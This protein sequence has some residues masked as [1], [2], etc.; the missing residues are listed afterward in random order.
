MATLFSVIYT[1]AL[2]KF[3]EQSFAVLESADNEDFLAQCLVSA[4]SDF[5]SQCRYDLSQLNV[6][7][8]AYVETLGNSEIDVLA[9][10]IAYYW[11]SWKV[12][13]SDNLV[14]TLSTKD[15]KF[16]SPGNLLKEMKELLIFFKEDFREKRINYSYSNA[17]ITNPKVGL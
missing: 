16:A 4:E 12:K 7:N 14:N 9:T 3:Q 13:N 10:G 8:D 11:L 2:S 5:A 17:N 6:A 1:N 15:A